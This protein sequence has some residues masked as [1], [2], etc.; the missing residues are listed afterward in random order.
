[1]LIL[2]TGNMSLLA[3]C[4]DGNAEKPDCLKN[5]WNSSTRFSGLYEG[6]SSGLTQFLAA[7]SPLKMME[8][9]F[10]FT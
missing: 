3:I 8:N 2:S 7:E 6:A 10:H 1:M 9:I 5:S 4:F